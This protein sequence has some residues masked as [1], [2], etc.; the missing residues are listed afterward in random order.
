M[1]LV[2]IGLPQS[3]VKYSTFGVFHEF[4]QYLLAQYQ[5]QP[6]R[7]VMPSFAAILISGK[8]PGKS[9]STRSPRGMKSRNTGRFKCC[10][11]LL[12]FSWWSNVAQRRTS[13]YLCSVRRWEKRCKR[14]MFNIYQTWKD[15]RWKDCWAVPSFPESEQRTSN[16]YGWPKIR[17]CK[18]HFI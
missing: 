8:S 3:K 9:G 14:G 17:W 5:C 4:L 2:D 18:R 1:G 10:K 6:A 15:N 11:L 7:A 12:Y 13:C 16:E